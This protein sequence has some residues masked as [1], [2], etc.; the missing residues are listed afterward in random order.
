METPVTK[1]FSLGLLLFQL[2]VLLVPIF[3]LPVFRESIEFPKYM[4]IFGMAIILLMLFSIRTIRTN[5]LYFHL[6]WLDLPV[7]LLAVTY[8]ISWILNAD[9]K[10]EIWAFPNSIGSIISLTLIY[11][12]ARQLIP[13]ITTKNI[14]IPLTI[15]ANIIAA[16]VTFQSLNQFFHFTDQTS[17]ASAIF[18]NSIVSL[19]GNLIYSVLFIVVTMVLFIEQILL[20]H[21]HR[22]LKLS[23]FSFPIIIPL[24]GVLS[25]TAYIISHRSSFPLQSYQASWEV[26]AETYK[27]PATLIYGVGP[28][29]Y[30]LTYLKGRPISTLSTNNWNISFSQGANHWFTLASEIGLLGVGAFIFLV[31][32]IVTIKEKRWELIGLVII[33]ALLPSQISLMFIFYILLI[34]IA[35]QNQSILK[36]PL[37]PSIF[38]STIQSSVLSLILGFLLISGSIY[39]GYLGFRIL[40]GEYYFTQSLRSGNNIESRVKTLDLAIQNNPYMS[41]YLVNRSQTQLAIAFALSRQKNLTPDQKTNLTNI[42]KV[43]TDNAKLAIRI[44]PSRANWEN[45]ATIYQSL[46]GADPQAQQW[47]LAAYRNALISDPYNPLIR[48]N[49]GK[50]F[51]NAKAYQSALQ[52]F[53]AA[54]SVKTDLAAAWY[55]EGSTQKQLSNIELARA[56]YQKSLTLVEPNSEEFTTIN[57]DLESLETP[58]TPQINNPEVKTKIELPEETGPQELDSSN[59]EPKSPT[60]SITLSPSPNPEDIPTPNPTITPKMTPT[61]SVTVEPTSAPTPISTPTPTTP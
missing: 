7:I 11:F 42:I 41:S 22:L 8:I 21:A 58:P 57:Q 59:S 46:I 23:L 30:E 52:Q 19:N 36:I 51:Y 49:L 1:K 47:T 54:R 34:T 4:I 10:W 12:L 14:L 16:S 40:R 56:A 43:A 3:Y 29:N 37:G 38:K 45:L 25:G 13:Q 15:S 32:R 33:F 28:S 48:I 44:R 5:Q 53:Q 2:A 26:T 39:A 24:I 18:T 20:K 50:V 55:W 17:G 31:I 6:S 35:N 61:L 27:Q 60:P 9:V